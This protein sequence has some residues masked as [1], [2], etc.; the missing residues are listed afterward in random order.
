MSEAL[1]PDLCI[2]GAGSAGLT[3]AAAARAAGL[4]VVLVERA[5]M[6]G[7]CLNTGCVPS[8]ALIAAARHAHAI[9]RAKAFG[10]DAGDPVVD[11]ARVHAHV[12][13]VIAGI[14]PH[15]SADRF[16]GLGA[17]VIEASARFVDPD[18]VEA[19]GR[20]IRAKRIVIATGSKPVVPDV[21]G[22]SA[23]PILTNE[24]LFDL[25]A[26]PSHLVVVGGGP[27]GL[28]MAQAFRRLGSAVSVISRGRP[29]RNDDA[30]AAALVVSRLRGEGVE[31]LAEA[32]LTAA[33]PLGAAGARLTVAVGGGERVL[34]ASHVLV[35]AGRRPALDGLDLAAGN[36]ATT[37]DGVDVDDAFRSRSNSRVFAI[38]DVAGSYRF[39]HWA[40]HQAGLVLR[41]ILTRLPAKPKASEI[42]WCTYTD[43]EI[44]H[45]GL[46]EAE[47]RV[48]HGGAVKVLRF[49]YAGNDRARADLETDGFVKLVTGSRG[50]ILG[51][52]IVG[53]GAGEL[54]GTVALAISAGLG[55]GALARTVLPYPTLGEVSK[56]A[57]MTTYADAL[58]KPL[59]GLALRFLRTTL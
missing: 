18:T 2:I 59:A 35:A 57:A 38:G 43:P 21:P 47:A 11:F 9:R 53:A 39:T 55:A 36:V 41:T 37:P 24:S 32:K 52:D 17:T 1:T 33:V 50:R 34:E 27:V 31:I 26:L 30:E 29:L 51:A 6:G 22:L 40:S 3:L 49:A 16:R 46:T 4:S 25:T 45:A 5:K 48:R 14:A 56:R 54:I 44:A 12:H 8:K 10:I 13:D 15:D 28:E 42:V 23:I 19:G 20:A 7:E 58:K